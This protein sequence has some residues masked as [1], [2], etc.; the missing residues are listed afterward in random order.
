MT[1]MSTYIQA[2]ATALSLITSMVLAILKFKE[3]KLSIEAE[4]QSVC[5]QDFQELQTKVAVLEE[6]INNEISMLDKLETKLDQIRDQ[7]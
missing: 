5:R 6:R 1:D 3:K 2:G 7:L 4:E